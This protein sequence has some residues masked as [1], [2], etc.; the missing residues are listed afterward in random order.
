M[1]DEVNASWLLP[2]EPAANLAAWRASPPQFLVD[3]GYGLT[4][5]SYESLAYEANVTTRYMKIVLFGFAKTLY[6]LAFTFRAEGV[7]GG[8]GDG[9]THVTVIGQAL[10]TTR[11]AL[12]AYVAASAAG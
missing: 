11:N 7:G 10:E 6:R 5:E 8:E 3:G 2:G 1:A 12:S 9:T 4:D